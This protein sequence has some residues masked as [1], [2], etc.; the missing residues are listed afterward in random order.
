MASF[1]SWRPWPVHAT[2][3]WGVCLRITVVTPAFNAAPFI[4]DSIRS[5]LAQTHRD[6]RLVVVDDG[7]TD[8]TASIVTALTDP[9]LTL[10]WQVNAGVAAARNRGMAVVEGGALLFLDADDWLAPAA[11][12]TLSATLDAAPEAVAAVG[13][14]ARVDETGRPIGRTVHPPPVAP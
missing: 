3:H 10:V 2:G 5:V 8:A 1:P 6:L 9:R 7:S 13:P 4:G 12:A 11:L 14:Y